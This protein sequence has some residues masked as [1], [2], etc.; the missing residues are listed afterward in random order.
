[1]IPIFSIVS[2]I[3]GWSIWPNND[4]IICGFHAISSDLLTGFWYHLVCGKWHMDALHMKFLVCYIW[5]NNEVQVHT[6]S[7]HRI[8]IDNCEIKLDF[9]S[10]LKLLMYRICSIIRGFENLI[11]PSCLFSTLMIVNLSTSASYEISNLLASF[12]LRSRVWSVIQ[13]PWCK[14]W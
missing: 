4:F 7:L 3:H 1:M 2:E 11:F 14:C 12:L 8:L 9:V 13:L 6:F 10:E 5:Y